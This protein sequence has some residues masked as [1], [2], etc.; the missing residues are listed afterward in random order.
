[1]NDSK[2]IFTPEQKEKL[3]KLAAYFD[4]DTVITNFLHVS[5]NLTASCLLMMDEFTSGDLRD[6]YGLSSQ[7][8]LKNLSHVFIA[9]HLLKIYMLKDEFAKGLEKVQQENAAEIDR[10]LN[11]F[12]KGE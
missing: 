3:V 12:E 4:E 8:V 9:L 6:V 11:A 10:L 5:S 2:K 7:D 1:M